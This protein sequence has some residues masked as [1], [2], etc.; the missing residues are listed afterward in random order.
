MRRICIVTDSTAD[1][2]ESMARKKGII[3]AP[4]TVTHKGKTYRDGVDL[5]TDELLSMLEEGEELPKTSQVNPQEFYKLY[6][7][8]LK[9]ECEIISIHISSDV[10]GTYQSAGIAKQMLET[11]KIHVVDSRAVSF[12]TGLLVL[13]AVKMVES[14]MVVDDIL[15]KLNEIATRVEVAFVV[16]N[17]EYLKKGGRLSGTQAAIGTL[18]NIKPILYMTKGKIEVLD[19]V[20][21]MKKAHNRLIGFMDDKKV[22]RNHGFAIGNVGCQESMIDFIGLI[23]GIISPEKVLT[24]DVGTVVSTYAGRGTIGVFFFR[25]L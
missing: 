3:V 25:E 10:S 4:L 14:G 7:E 13:E 12:G 19:K 5:K 9:E 1:I 24:A 11:D 6:S 18:L 22:D 2:P 15:E 8:I 21:G 23:N 20:R 17:L 16:D